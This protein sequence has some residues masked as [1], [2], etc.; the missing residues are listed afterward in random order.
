MAVVL[1][2]IPAIEWTAVGRE[3]WDFVAGAKKR[4]LCDWIGSRRSATQ[5]S[6]GPE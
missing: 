1:H 4:G 5:E 2:L 6:G 3:F